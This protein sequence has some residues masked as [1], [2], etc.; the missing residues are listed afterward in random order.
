MKILTLVFLVLLSHN[1]YSQK[2][3]F[4]R[5]Y[6]L[7]GKKVNKG[8]L[9]T[10]TDTSLQVKGK[11]FVDI[12]VR[13]IGSIKTKHLVGNNLLVGSTIG[14]FSMAIIGAASA[15]PDAEILGYTAGEGAAAGA[16]IGLPIGAAIGGLTILFQNSK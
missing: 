7:T 1:I 12:P 13:S 2:S 4:V 11:S 8:H 10:I 9:L 3:I 6:D 16:L 15:E 5:V 14:V